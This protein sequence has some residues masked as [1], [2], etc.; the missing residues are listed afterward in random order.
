M[1]RYTPNHMDLSVTCPDAGWLLVTDRWAHGWR[2]V[3][4]GQPAELFGGNFI[5]RAVRVKSG[6]N[7]ID[8]SYRPFGFPVLLVLSWGTLAAVFV[9]APLFRWRAKAPQE[10]SVLAA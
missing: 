8:F 4:N 7:R 3:V 1:L 10:S 6:K 2:A 9:G 5:F